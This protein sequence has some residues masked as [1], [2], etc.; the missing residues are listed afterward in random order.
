MPES[1]KNPPSGLRHFTFFFGIPENI[2]N[3]H[4]KYLPPLLI[5]R[6]PRPWTRVRHIWFCC[7]LFLRYYPRRQPHS[8]YLR[9]LYYV[10][11]Y[12][13]ISSI[14]AEKLEPLESIV[15]SFIPGVMNAVL[16]RQKN[17]INPELRV[18]FRCEAWQIDDLSIANYFGTFW[19]SGN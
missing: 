13:T 3:L 7:A 11:V 10:R 16:C 6:V 2:L 12:V 17:W 5:S 9:T 19:D 18:F 4:R 14:F 15:I 1:S 8:T